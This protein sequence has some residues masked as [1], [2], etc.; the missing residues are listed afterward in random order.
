MRMAASRI[1]ISC[2]PSAACSAPKSLASRVERRCHNAPPPRKVTGS[3]QR[4]PLHAT[5]SRR[6]LHFG[7]CAC[8]RQ[9]VPSRTSAGLGEQKA[10]QTVR[11]P[12][13]VPRDLLAV[14]SD[15][16]HGDPRKVTGSSQ[17]SPLHA[18]GSRRCLDFGKCACK[19]HVPSRTLAGLGEQKA[20]QAVRGPGASVS[21]GRVRIHLPPA[22]SP[23][24]TAPAVGAGTPLRKGG[25]DGSNPAPSSE[26]S[27]NHRFLSPH[28]CDRRIKIQ[29]GEGT[30]LGLSIAY[31]MVTQQ[32][33][34]TIEVDSRCGRPFPCICRASAWC[35][36]RP[37][38]A[39]AAAASS[40][41]LART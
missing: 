22:K 2:G 40:P 13:G 37:P 9:L 19:R 8:K 31:D 35:S 34:G 12:A 26:E 33:G 1:V 41:S 18:A 32:H 23:R 3:S 38:P 17:R 5:G 36:Q 27:A 6:C 14:L 39:R 25:T 24:R 16:G 21:R 11:R 7:K 10:N 4:S 29:T 15:E 30:G 28:A 20:N